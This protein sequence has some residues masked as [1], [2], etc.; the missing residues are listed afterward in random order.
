MNIWWNKQH[1]GKVPKQHRARG[2]NK[3]NKKE[4]R[5]ITKTKNDV[6]SQER[7]DRVVITGCNKPSQK[8][9][10]CDAIDF[11]SASSYAWRTFDLLMMISG[12]GGNVLPT[13]W[14][15]RPTTQSLSSVTVTVSLLLFLS[16]LHRFGIRRQS[17]LRH[18]NHSFTRLLVPYHANNHWVVK[19]PWNCMQISTRLMIETMVQ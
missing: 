9:T 6:L 14:W 10:K 17:L 1:D 13:E 18:T 16:F 19:L 5:P 12:K 15:K 4:V 8:C 7:S 3:R 11:E 2:Q